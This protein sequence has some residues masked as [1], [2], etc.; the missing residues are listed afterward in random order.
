MGTKLSNLLLAA[1]LVVV[2]S[3]AAMAQPPRLINFQ[4]R[5][6]DAT[7]VPVADGNHTFDF[8]S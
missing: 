1:F 3:A 2:F 5:V 6:L 8:F 7:G 4:G